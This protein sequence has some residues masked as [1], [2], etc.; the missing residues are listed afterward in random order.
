MK[1]ERDRAYNNWKD[2]RR[3]AIKARNKAKK[4]AEEIAEKIRDGL[5]GVKDGEYND[6]EVNEIT[7]LRDKM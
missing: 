3:D 6:G 5:D 4:Q 1:K 7:E 2:A